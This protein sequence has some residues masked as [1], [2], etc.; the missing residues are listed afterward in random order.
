MQTI[1]PYSKR[2]PFYNALIRHNLDFR[3]RIA[4]AKVIKVGLRWLCGPYCCL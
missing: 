4:K 2:A 3:A 1:K